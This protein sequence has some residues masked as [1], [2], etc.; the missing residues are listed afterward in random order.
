MSNMYKVSGVSKLCGEGVDISHNVNVAIT[1]L[2]N[3]LENIPCKVISNVDFMFCEYSKVLRAEVN[4]IMYKKWSFRWFIV[5]I[6]KILKNRL[7]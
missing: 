3:N 6:N 5:K 2:I 4:V 7:V 1:D